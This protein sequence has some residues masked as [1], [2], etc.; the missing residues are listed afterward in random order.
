MAFEPVR[1]SLMY[2]DPPVELTFA[3]RAEHASAWLKHRD[4]LI[5]WCTANA[6]GS[7]PR[8]WWVLEQNS[9]RPVELMDELRK[10]I[11]LGVVSDAERQA[12]ETRLASNA[13][14]VAG[15]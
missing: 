1:A 8:S 10:L 3:T 7:R 13:A 11:A 5:G 4:E 14:P 2:G 6:P 12:A 9:Y 15:D